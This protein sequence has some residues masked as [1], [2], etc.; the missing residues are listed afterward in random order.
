MEHGSRPFPN[1][2][3]T[4][5]KTAGFQQQYV[6]KLLGLNNH[7]SLSAWEHGKQMPNG[8]HL[9]K[10]CILYNTT[11]SELYPDLYEKIKQTIVPKTL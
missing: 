8:M 1:R 4:F 9:I 3:R 2:L 7:P 11:P 6:A 10:L 5:R